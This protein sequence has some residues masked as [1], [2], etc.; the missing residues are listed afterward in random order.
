MSDSYSGIR[1]FSTGSQLS[2]YVLKTSL[3][4]FKLMQW[5]TKIVGRKGGCGCVSV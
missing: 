5:L 1:P 2:S 3:L 4:M